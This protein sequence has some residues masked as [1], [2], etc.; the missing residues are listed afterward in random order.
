MYNF[1]DT[2]ESQASTQLPSEALKINGKW[3]EDQVVGYRTLYVSG[4]E[5]FLKE[6]EVYEDGI[7][8]GSMI[9]NRRYPIRTIKVGYQ[10]IASS[11]TAFRTAF[12]KLNTVLNT[13]DAQLIFHDEE[14]KYF[15]GTPSG[16]GE[17]PPGTNAITSEF[18]IVCVDPFKYAVNEKELVVSLDENGMYSFNYDGTYNAYPVLEADVKSDLGFVGFV[19]EKEKVIQIGNPAET[20][21]EAYFSNKKFVDWNFNMPP[22]NQGDWQSNVA[23][24]VVS[25]DPHK[26]NGTAG[27][28]SDR[29]GISIQS[30]TSFGSG[31]KWHGASVTKVLDTSLTDFKLEWQHI[32]VATS[33]KQMGCMQ[34]L[35][36]GK[37]E[38]GAKE[39]IAAV[40]IFKGQSSSKTAKVYM[41]VNGKKKKET[42]FTASETS[43]TA[44]YYNGKASIEV[45]AGVFV[46]NIGGKKYSVTMFGEKK[47]TEVSLYFGAWGSGAK[48]NKNGVYS[49]KLRG[50]VLATR[51]TANTFSDGDKIVVDCKDGTIK[52]N[53]LDEPGLGAIG[54]DWEG[55]YLTPGV[56]TIACTYSE[57]NNAVKPDFR[58]RYREVFV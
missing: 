24:T 39:N 5:S 12:N 36:T 41:F 14:D 54:N 7:R 56:N 47:L 50:K 55:F 18:E 16:A 22:I 49:V 20:D 11:N 13:E 8:D 25:R 27:L 40:Y 53:G 31:D 10:L 19:N 9:K 45:N 28:V 3:I 6:S 46:F 29:D 34:I 26:Q 35:L 42:S 17:I 21:E 1:I 43:K 23:T 57:W 33:A 38:S 58:I 44:G 4:R 32:F 30:V 15:T 51:D 2:T 48:M 52:V 37:N